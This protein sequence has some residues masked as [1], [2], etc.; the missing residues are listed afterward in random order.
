M[1]KIW[2]AVTVVLLTAVSA[3]VIVYGSSVSDRKIDTS[4]KQTYA[5]PLATCSTEDTITH[6]FA[7]TFAEEVERLSGGEMEIQVYPQSTLGGDRELMESCKDGD[8][9][10]VVQSP[11]P[12]VSF[13]PELCVFDTPCVFD[14]IEEA[15]AAIDDP[16]FFSVIQGIYEDAGY[17]ILG[18]ADQCF[19]V[20]T[21]SEPFTGMESFKGQKIRTME[22]TYH[23]QFWNAVGASPTPMTFSEVYIGL[24]QGTIDA[25]ENAYELI[26]SAKLYEQQEV[27]VQTNAVPDYITLIVSDDF[28]R[29][30]DKEQQQI[31]RE[32]AAIAQEKARESADERREQREEELAAEGMEIVEIDQQTWEEMQ[33]ACQP[34]YENIR[35]QAGDELVDLYMGVE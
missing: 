32:A 20:M 1:K 35:K 12:Q 33:E 9:P 6:V 15:R 11:A 24:Q 29:D 10:F 23:I 17:Q 7:Q 13:M 19:R 5:W 27:L 28:F 26:V 14:D 31:V 22:N 30:L 4:G 21:S 2:S 8:I 25:Q 34:V 18:M 16:E 3:G